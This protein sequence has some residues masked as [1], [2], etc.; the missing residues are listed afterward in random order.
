MKNKPTLLITLALMATLLV[1]YSSYVVA[2]PLKAKRKPAH[3]QA[4]NHLSTISFDLTNNT[5]LNLLPVSKP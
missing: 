1:C 5:A 2:H 4:V 3:L